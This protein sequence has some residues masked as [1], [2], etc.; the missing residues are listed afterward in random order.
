MGGVNC[1][2]DLQF[3]KYGSLVFN[4]GTYDVRFQN[5]LKVPGNSKV[6]G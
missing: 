1:S 2:R 4:R 6:D 5:I 3:H